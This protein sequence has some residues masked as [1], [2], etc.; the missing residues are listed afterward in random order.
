MCPDLGRASADGKVLSMRAAHGAAPL[1]PGLRELPHAD[2]LRSASP[3]ENFDAVGALARPER[4]E[5]GDR[6]LRG[7][8]RRHAVQRRR[9]S[10]A[11]RSC[12]EPDT[13]LTTLTEKLLTYAVGRGLAHYDAPAVRAIRRDGRDAARTT[14]SQRSDPRHRRQSDVLSDEEDRSHDHHA[15]WRCRGERSCAGSAPTLALPLLDAMVPALSAWS[16]RR[17]PAVPPAGIHLR[18]ERRGH[19]QV[20]ADAERPGLRALA[21]SQPARAVPRSACSS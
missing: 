21:D 8:A 13:F 9:G 19:G 18:A 10:C 12:V 3:L 2:G 20:D 15:R 1:Q 17:R 16:R 11:R 4:V 7:A 6:R 14:G 5:R